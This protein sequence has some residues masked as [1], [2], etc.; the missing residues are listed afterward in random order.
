M[1][2]SSAD[3]RARE[4]RALDQEQTLVDLDQSIAEREQAR[5]DRDQQLLDEAQ[6]SLDADGPR[7]DVD[8]STARALVNQ[9][10]AD[11]GLAQDRSDAHQV[12]LDDGQRAQDLRRKVLDQQQAPLDQPEDDKALISQ[13]PPDAASGRDRALRQ[14]AFAALARAEQAHRRAE[15]ALRRVEAYERRK[16]ARETED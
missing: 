15:Q 4:Q 7:T 12:Q 10:Q 1:T 14:R 16:Q 8:D 6:L 2:P 3:P 13:A 5:A 9:R 11:L